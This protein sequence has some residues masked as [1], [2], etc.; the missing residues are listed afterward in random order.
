[1]VC[2]KCDCKHVIIWIVFTGLILF[3]NPIPK[4]YGG[5]V[6]IS[7]DSSSRE[8]VLHL[9]NP[10]SGT[11]TQ[12]NSFSFDTNAWTP[13]T[14]SSNPLSGRI[15]AISS[16]DTLYEFS[17]TTGEVLSM[18]TPDL[19]ESIQALASS[20][21]TGLKGIYYNGNEKN[22]LVSID[23]DNSQ[24]NDL[25]IFSF[26]DNSWKPPSFTSSFLL[27]NIYA[28]S[29]EGS[30]SS[31]LNVFSGT[32]GKRL[33]THS[34][35]ISIQAMDASLGGQ[36]F[37][38]TYNSIA[39]E[40]ELYTINPETGQVTLL[41]SFSFD[42]G[43]WAPETFTTNP[44]M[45]RAYAVSSSGKLYEFNLK[46]GQI[47]ST[48]DMGFKAQSL[49]D[50]YPLFGDNRFY[51]GSNLLIIGDGSTGSMKISNGGALSDMNVRIGGSGTGTVS[52]TGTD[53]LLDINELT[54]GYRGN[55]TLSVSDGGVITSPSGYIGY[56]ENSIGR[57]IVSGSSSSWTNSEDIVVG[58]AGSG[59]LS[60]INGAS[61]TTS[62]LSIG[63]LENGSG[64]VLVNGGG[65]LLDVESELRMGSKAP[66]ALI[67]SKNGTV[68][69]KDFN[70]FKNGF[71][72]GNGKVESDNII[73]HGAIGP[74]SSIGTL[75]IEGDLDF[76]PGSVLEIE[77]D[78]QGNNDLL[79]VNGAVTI[80]GGEVNAVVNSPSSTIT[81]ALT[82]TIM[83]AE[84]ITGILA[85][86]ESKA[87][88]DVIVLKED[89]TDESAMV[90]KISP[91]AFDSLGFVKESYH[92]RIL[93]AIFQNMADLGGN[94]ITTALQSADSI[95]QLAESY[96]QL[97]GQ[98]RA[99]LGSVAATGT[100][101]FVGVVSNRIQTLNTEAQSASTFRQLLSMAE[102]PV[103]SGDYTSDDNYTQQILSIGQGGLIF[104]FTDW[105]AW[106]K[107]HGV[108]GDQDKGTDTSGYDY[109]V[110]GVAAGM[111]YQVAENFV[112]GITTGYAD[113]E[114]DYKNMQDESR[115][116]SLYGGIYGGYQ[117]DGWYL[118]SVVT[119]TDLNNETDRYIDLT[120]EHLEG[121]FDGYQVTGY[122]EAGVDLGKSGGWLHQALASSQVSYQ[123][124]D[125]YTET[126]G[127]SALTYEGQ[128]FTSVK[129]SLGIKTS[130][131]MILKEGYA[132]IIQFRGRWIHEF[133]DTEL[134]VDASFANTPSSTFTIKDDGVARDSASVGMGFY[135]QFNDNKHLLFDYDFRVNPDE[136]AHTVSATFRY[137]W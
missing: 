105:G 84:S 55:G 47:L 3:S 85:P 124:L 120:S 14:F 86:P 75:T 96:T 24:T 49:T 15:Y 83:Q 128:D 27:K 34:L 63:S 58:R 108:F 131:N 126:G 7:Y 78:N 51:S 10:D 9:I 66:G 62:G 109:K 113:S 135:T 136:T 115:V 97:S 65:S 57:V 67:V 35:G 88:L 39:D 87:L 125:N 28:I 69:V 41:N 12:L 8:N 56:H 104:P 70:I 95:E 23:P 107:G 123:D 16:S 93:G 4:A 11:A 44:L 50:T 132:A 26:S 46:T 72:G 103:F 6:S 122:V 101:Q 20:R 40:N 76:E 116:D 45:N 59:L 91:K 94:D 129:G 33:S 22:T 52:I 89:D 13:A 119:Y 73:N 133:A 21:G 2:S 60:I 137:Q 114:V 30:D 112:L 74:G 90:L 43:S 32:T 99:S 111:D 98:T 42:T 71:L 38:I 19:P 127:S 5:L 54:V 102:P 110:A 68:K 81:E 77:V 29:S 18:Q 80:N 130:N 118:H 82:Y 134:N 17:E 61:V 53:S 106:V 1:M 48:S 31:K 92:H 100:G 36:L 25:S 79:K 37:G 121:D 117:P 64:I